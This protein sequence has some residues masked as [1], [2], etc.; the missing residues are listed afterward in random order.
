MRI[1]RRFVASIVALVVLSLGSIAPQLAVAASDSP[2]TIALTATVDEVQDWGNALGGAIH[3]GD[4]ITGTYTY[5]AATS[6]ISP[7]PNIGNYLHTSAPYGIS[8]KAGGKIF[9]TDPQKVHFY[10]Y[11]QNN[12][13]GQDHYAVI[14][15]SNRPLSEHY[16]VTWISWW[17]DDPSQTALKNITLPKTAPKLGNWQQSNWGLVVDGE[18]SDPNSEYT[19]RI[20]AHVTQAQKI[21]R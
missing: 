7:T 4:T 11:L 18:A 17:L 2:I 15:D 3:P 12:F 14:S 16:N 5:N 8:L 13:Y 10:V 1:Y 20:R 19:F 6:N 9:E 21:S